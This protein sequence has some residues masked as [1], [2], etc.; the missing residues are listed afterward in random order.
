MESR[1][2]SSRT[3]IT[4]VSGASR[5][6]ARGLN[7]KLGSSNKVPAGFQKFQIP[8]ELDKRNDDGLIRLKP[9]IEKISV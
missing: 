9:V 6:G 8:P 7:P 5:H 3:L 1:T 2:I 4:G